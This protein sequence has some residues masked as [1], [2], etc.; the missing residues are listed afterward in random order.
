MILSALYTH[1]LPVLARPLL[2]A[3]RR[4][5]PTIFGVQLR[6]HRQRSLQRSTT[7]RPVSIGFASRCPRRSPLVCFA[8]PLDALSVT[9]SRRASQWLLRKRSPSTAGR[10]AWRLVPSVRRRMDDRPSLTIAAY[11]KPSPWPHADGSRRYESHMDAQ[12]LIVRMPSAAVLTH[13]RQDKVD[14]ALDAALSR[15]GPVMLNTGTFY[16]NPDNVRLRRR[17]AT[18]SAADV[19]PRCDR[20]LDAPQ[21]GSR[22]AVRRLRQGRHGQCVE[23]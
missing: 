20:R 15:G 16:G 17:V 4:G 13:C 22:V 7:A 23:L 12:A 14:G 9:A 10:M 8:S 2:S 5:A 18:N 3:L 11:G 21:R 6:P 19:Q 1:A